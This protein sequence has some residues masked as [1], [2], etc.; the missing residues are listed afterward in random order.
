MRT[1]RTR[2]FRLGYFDG[3][4]TREFRHASH[5]QFEATTGANRIRIAVD[6][7][8]LPLLLQLALSSRDSSAFVLYVLHTSRCDNALGRYQSALLSFYA[9]N[10]LA[11]EFGDFLSHDGRHDLWLH[12]PDSCVTVVWDR[13]DLIFGYG[14]LESLRGILEH[15]GIQEGIVDPLPEP[16]VHMYHPQYDD[17]EREILARLSW[18]RTALALD[19]VQFSI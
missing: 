5:F 3:V 2:F 14:P 12:C 13:H 19:E 18:H 7:G 17:D 8:H 11:E 6:S 15:N 1:D 4:E 9:I 16:H 10:Q